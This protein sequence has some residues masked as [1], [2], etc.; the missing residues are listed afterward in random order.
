MTD[1]TTS[2]MI[3]VE[4]L[5]KQLREV[6][7][8]IVQ[9]AATVQGHHKYYPRNIMEGYSTNNSMSMLGVATFQK[10]YFT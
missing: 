2:N 5:C 1:Q 8:E 6:N 4:Q 7:L 9:C 3:S 10:S